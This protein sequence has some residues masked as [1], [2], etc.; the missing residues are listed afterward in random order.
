VTDPTSAPAI[1]RL[2]REL[3]AHLHDASPA[4][5]FDERVRPLVAGEAEDCAAG[6]WGDLHDGLTDEALAELVALMA[7]DGAPARAALTIFADWSAGYLA[8]IIAV[9]VL[10]DGVLVRLAQPGALRVL[11][12]PKGWYEDVCLAHASAIVAADHPWA[13]RDD[14]A[15]VADQAALELAAI[16]EIVEACTPLVDAIATRSGRGRAGLWAQVADGVGYVPHLLGDLAP[17]VGA[18]VAAAATAR[19]LATPGAPWKHVPRFWMAESSENPVLV[20]HRGSCCLYYRWERPAGDEPAEEALDAV[21]RAYRE[22][23]GDDAPHYCSTCMFRKPDDV[24][25]RV[26]FT[27]EYARMADGS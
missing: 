16:A 18:R 25:A 14:V 23:F 20:T 26:V 10:R 9:G 27:A 21:H 6:T 3:P 15:V 12:D 7:E 5:W 24:Q 19:L 11:R 1:T 2:A 13:H 22:R 4:T 8:Q 17:P